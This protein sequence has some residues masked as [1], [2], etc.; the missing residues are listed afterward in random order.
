LKPLFHIDAFTSKPFSGNP[1]AVVLVDRMPDEHWMQSV[2]AEMNLSETAFVAPES[3][4]FLLRWFTPKAEVDLCGHATLASAHA[5]WESEATKSDAI[6]FSTRSGVLRAARVENGIELDFPA[7]P[8]R[9]AQMPQSLTE[10]VGG[11]CRYIG[12][13]RFDHLLEV[14]SQRELVEL[15]PHMPLLAQIPGRG[16]IVTSPPDD[17]KYDFASRFFAPAVGIDEDPVT[18]SA[19][20]CLGPFWGERLSKNRML[21]YQA[22]PRGGEVGVKVKGDRVGLVGRAVTIVRGQIIC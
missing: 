5:L 11:N 20:C 18:G 16:V 17:P 3:D 7:E 1:A 10:T 12:R 6:S 19:H 22:S 13:N 14:D 21:A 15:R 4:H 8:V 9:Q 2:A